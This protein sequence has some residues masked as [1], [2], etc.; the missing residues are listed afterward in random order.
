M[1]TSWTISSVLGNES[2]GYADHAAGRLDRL[3]LTVELV[4]EALD[5]IQAISDD[6]V[7]PRQHSFHGGV[8]LSPG[9]LFRLRRVVDR[10]RQAQRLVIDEVY[11]QP[12]DSGIGACVGNGGLEEIL[13]LQR[14]RGLPRGGVAGDEDK[15]RVLSA[16][17][18]TCKSGGE[19]AEGSTHGHSSG[20]NVACGR[21]ADM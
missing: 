8:F 15:L 16:G 13:E 1:C 19:Q 6:D 2:R 20:T 12:G 9:I 4:A 7:I 18:D 11:L 21:T 14:A 17:L 5:I 3:R 10:P